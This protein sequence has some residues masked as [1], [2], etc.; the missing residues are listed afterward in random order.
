MLYYFV[1]LYYVSYC[2]ICYSN[3]SPLPPPPRRGSA[4]TSPAIY[5]YIYIYV[6]MYTIHSNIHIYIYIPICISAWSP[7]ETTED[8]QRANVV[9]III[10]MPNIYY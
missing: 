10:I 7:A 2:S 4:I 8:N 1:L 6:C 9:V 5:I 3:A